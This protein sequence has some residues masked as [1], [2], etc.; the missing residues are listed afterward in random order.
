MTTF[1][2]QLVGLLCE[3]WDQYDRDLAAWF[4]YAVDVALWPLMAVLLVTVFAYVTG[5][6]LTDF[7]SSVIASRPRR[8]RRAGSGGAK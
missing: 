7:R 3:C 1:D 4:D 5:L 8:A 6:R 2:P